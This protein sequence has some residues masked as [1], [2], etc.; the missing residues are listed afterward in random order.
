[1]SSSRRRFLSGSLLVLAL[2][3]PACASRTTG[4]TGPTI[5][6]L[7]PARQLAQTLD[8]L[9]ANSPADRV[10]WGV[11]VRV[12]GGGSL[13]QRNANLLLHPA[14]NMKLV[15]L[16]TSAERLGWD[17]RFET[18]IRA[19]SPVD[20]D[21]TVA[22]DLVVIGGGDPT[23]SRRHDGHATL[24]HLADLV[25]QRGVRRIEGRIIGDGSAF[26]GTSY[27][28]GWQWD[29][30]PFSYAAPVS[31]LT[32]N[33]NTA[34]FVVAPGPSAGA[35]AQMTLVDG[36]ADLDIVNEITTVA[37]GT[38]RRLSI[39]RRPNEARVTIRGEVPLGLAPFKQYL[40]IADPP[41]YFA[42]AF[43]QAL[44]ARGIT[45]IGAARS[46]VTDPPGRLDDER[47]VSIRHQ[48]P[49][50]REIAATLMKV[51]QNL[52]AEVLFHALGKSVGDKATGA[53]A[54]ALAVPSWGAD[55]GEV[56][57]ADGSGLS[58]YDLTSAAALDA[59]LSRM[60]TAPAHRE[61]WVAALPIAGVDGTLERRMRGTPAEGRVHA[62]TGSIAYVRALSGYVQAVDGEWIQFVI[63]ANNFAGKVTAA[64]VDRITDQ[65]VN[66]LVGFSLTSR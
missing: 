46:A 42:H 61:P 24:A 4:P 41:T 25:W 6:T 37:S 62:K 12:P 60:F 63:L 43:R 50:L 66:L 53:D 59:L 40:A 32:Y 22:G 45:V 3:S 30:L 15:T 56:V 52:Y 18:T 9:F 21:G 31:A 17:F 16:A 26:G 48:S 13:Y 10:V 20:S 14:S 29:D 11:S 1:M 2:W 54:I 23:I 34:E 49:P 7:S 39:D 35:L 28:E 27:G 57:A 8:K 44:V 64:D 33:E 36:S 65:A 55:P 38:A 19:T 58:R 51:S 5:P 47:G